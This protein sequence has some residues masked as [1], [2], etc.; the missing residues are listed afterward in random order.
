MSSSLPVLDPQAKR[1][2]RV[3]PSFDLLLYRRMY[4][5]WETSEVLIDYCDVFCET[6]ST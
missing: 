3:E 1:E 5:H 2:N 6:S 4:R